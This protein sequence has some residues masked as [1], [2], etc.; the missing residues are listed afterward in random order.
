MSR[1]STPSS[2]SSPSRPVSE[3]QEEIASLHISHST[4]VAQVNTLSKDIHE[5]RLVNAELEEENEGYEF[6]LKERTLSGKVL[7]NPNIFGNGEYGFAS[8]SQ[9]DVLDEQLEMEELHSDLQAQSPIFED[10]H[11][12]ERDLDQISTSPGQ[13]GLTP[14]KK[15]MRKSRSSGG[16]KDSPGIG[17]TT[18]GLDLAA[19]LGRAEVDLGDDVVAPTQGQEEVNGES[20]GTSYATGHLLT[21][22]A[23]LRAELQTLRE[24]NKALSLYCS[25]VSRLYSV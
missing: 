1:N 10:G 7:E 6:L 22:S 8:P 13:G 24:S 17:N 3:L 15:I 4:L 18:G 16:K 21:L 5:L 20:S 12:S 2:T 14:Q 9:L 19:E 11:R 25:K 23:A